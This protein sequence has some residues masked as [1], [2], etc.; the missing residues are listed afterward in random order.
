[1]NNSEYREL[2][3]DFILRFSR[4]NKLSKFENI[5]NYNLEELYSNYNISYE[6]KNI[7]RKNLIEYKKIS[8]MTFLNPN[9]I[10]WMNE[11]LIYKINDKVVSLKELRKALTKAKK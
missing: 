8:D 6:T 5:F 11:M 4:N 7:L 10:D 9:K 1:M 3:Y 2:G